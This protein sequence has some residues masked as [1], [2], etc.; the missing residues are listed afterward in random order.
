V[1]IPL[2]PDR[3]VGYWDRFFG[4]GTKAKDLDAAL[5]FFNWFYSY[6]GQTLLQNLPEGVL[7]EKG[8]DSKAKIKSSAW[9]Y[10]SNTVPIPEIGGSRMNDAYG[11]INT[12]IFNGGVINPVTGRPMGMGLW[13]DYIEY[14]TASNVLMQNWAKTH[15]GYF[16]IEDYLRD[17]KSKQASEVNLAYSFMPTISEELNQLSVQIGDIFQPIAWKMVYAKDEAEFESLWKDLQKQAEI[18]GI[19]RII[20]WGK[21]AWVEAQKSFA[22]LK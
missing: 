18:M 1:S 20:D 12:N 8:G 4:I 19:Q 22:E 11:I 9:D 5:R 7:W 3:I 13:P 2:P 14:N 6:E 21:A 17:T 16:I 10:L 15:N